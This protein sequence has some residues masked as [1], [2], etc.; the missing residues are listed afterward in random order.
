MKPT[1]TH[2]F[3]SLLEESFKKRKNLET[4]SR[5]TAKIITLRDDFLIR[6]NP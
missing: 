4:G 6:K 1:K 2:D 5:H 3:A